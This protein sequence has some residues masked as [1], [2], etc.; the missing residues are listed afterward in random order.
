MSSFQ[1][2]GKPLD[3]RKDE[4][5]RGAKLKNHE[6][7]HAELTKNARICLYAEASYTMLLFC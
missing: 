3:S 7:Q 2:D 5:L 4:H 1:R 6:R